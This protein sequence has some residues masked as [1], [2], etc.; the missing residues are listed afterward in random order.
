MVVEIAVL[1][2]ADRDENSNNAA[3]ACRPA[4]MFEKALVNK[5]AEERNAAENRMSHHGLSR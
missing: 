5:L 3:R 4:A 1:E 2:E